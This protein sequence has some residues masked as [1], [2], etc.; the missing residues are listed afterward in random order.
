MGGLRRSIIASG[1][2]LGLGH[3]AGPGS[4]GRR[5]VA[6]TKLVVD[7]TRAGMACMIVARARMTGGRRLAT[8]VESMKGTTLQGTTGS[9]AQSG[10]TD[11]AARAGMTGDAALAGTTGGAAQP[12][13]TEGAAHPVMSVIL[14]RGTTRT[15]G[16]CAQLAEMLEC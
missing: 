1:L 8:G 14:G 12:P 13:T 4:T 11:A 5:T 3:L 9:T 2:A 15:A 10:M 16:G 6:G 7:M